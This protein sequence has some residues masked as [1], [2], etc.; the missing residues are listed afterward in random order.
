MSSTKNELSPLCRFPNEIL[1]QIL[2]Y[3]NFEEPKSVA[4]ICPGFITPMGYARNQ[5]VKKHREQW[6]G[7]RTYKSR[8]HKSWFP[9][10]SPI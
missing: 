1:D 10:Q 9:V 4:Q 3:L 8:C 6:E 7:L 2:M 5:R